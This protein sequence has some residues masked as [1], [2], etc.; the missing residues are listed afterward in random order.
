MAEE[1][2]E[3]VK[4]AGSSFGFWLVVIIVVI[5]IGSWGKDKNTPK[6]TPR[7]EEVVVKKPTTNEHLPFLRLLVTPTNNNIAV[8]IA[9]TSETRGLG[10]SGFSSL[11]KDQ[12]MLFIFPSPGYYPFW[13]KDMKFAI[14]IVWIKTLSPGYLQVLGVHEQVGPETYPNRITFD[15][16]PA[17]TVLEIPAGYARPYGIVPGAI[18]RY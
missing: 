1:P 4:K 11:P 14:D 15:S 13:M 12:G 8:R 17:D 10:L 2:K 18:I 7:N 3:V 9:D 5:I 16:A 6:E